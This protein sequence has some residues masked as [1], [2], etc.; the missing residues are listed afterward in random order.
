MATRAYAWPVIDSG[1]PRR[2]ISTA[3]AVARFVAAGLVAATAIGLGAYWVV[4]R[5][6]V[7][8]AIR[9]AQEIAAIDGRNVVAPALSDQVVGGEPAALTA[10]DQLVRDRVLSSRVVRVKI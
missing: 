2:P 4:S 8:E 3:G 9:H 10:F 6:A 7:A 1:R 5:N